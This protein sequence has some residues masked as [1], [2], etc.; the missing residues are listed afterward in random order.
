MCFGDVDENDRGAIAESLMECLDAAG[1]AAKGRS[2]EA[3]EDDDKRSTL[4]ER[5]E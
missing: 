1:P 3:A 2:G 5:R 4:T